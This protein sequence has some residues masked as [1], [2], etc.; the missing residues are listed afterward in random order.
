ML[1]CTEQHL[2][3]KN[4]TQLKYSDSK[5]CSSPHRRLAD[6]EQD[7]HV[8]MLQRARI[9][10][11]S[12]L[13]PLGHDLYTLIWNQL[14]FAGCSHVQCQ[15]LCPHTYTQSLVY[16]S[17]FLIQSIR[18]FRYTACCLFDIRTKHI[19]SL[20]I[21]CEESYTS[22]LVVN[23]IASVFTENQLQAMVPLS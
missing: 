19:V 14:K 20:T 4:S 22:V 18:T 10:S 16:F 21:S 7:S 11:W 6:T 9:I 2:I 3:P 1:Y 13:S 17:H 8:P 23:Y 15:L 12:S 5:N